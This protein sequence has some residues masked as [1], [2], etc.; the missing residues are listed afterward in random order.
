MC[1]NH[2]MTNTQHQGKP[3][4]LAVFDFD[5]TMISGDSIVPFVWQAVKEGHLSPLKLPG[6]GLHTWRALKGRI[7]ADEGKT[8]SLQFLGAMDATKRMDFCRRFCSEKLMPRVFP[9]ALG[10]L[11][12]H[13]Q[14]GDAVVLL[15]ASP[16][17]YLKHMGPLLQVN[18]VLASPTDE[19]GVV[20]RNTRGEEKVRRLKAWAQAQPFE[21][22]WAASHAYG[23]S[24]HDL[25]VMRLCG[26]PILVNPKPAMR[27]QAPDLPEETWT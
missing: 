4:A 5:G 7:T 20:T 11:K 13:L 23:D 14:A 24:A 1:Y 12:Q 6:I 19:T 3:R 26:H 9:Q 17:I 2:P 10:R 25:M 27:E 8:R 16:S 15:S 21:V 22:D 18:A